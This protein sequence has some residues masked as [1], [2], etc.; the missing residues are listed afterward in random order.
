MITNS[1]LATMWSRHGPWSTRFKG[2]VFFFFFFF[3]FVFCFFKEFLSKKVNFSLPPL[4]CPTF[5]SY[6][7]IKPSYFP[8]I[9]RSVFT[10]WLW[11]L[12]V[13]SLSTFVSPGSSILPGTQLFHTHTTWHIVVA[14]HIVI[15]HTYYW[16][17]VITYMY[18]LA[19]SY[20]IYMLPGP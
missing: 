6:F 4:G 19:H 12:S 11:A 3:W 15:I 8:L 1:H 5:C 9:S 10:S 7:Y 16:L 17:I 18:C 2:V 20:Y 13:Y 14:W